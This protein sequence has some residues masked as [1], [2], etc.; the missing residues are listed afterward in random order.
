VQSSTLL[1]NGDLSNASQ[2]AVNGGTLGGTG[3]VGNT[4][5]NAGGTLAPGA[6]GS[7]SAGNSTL[8]ISGNLA[9]RSGA[10]YLVQVNPTLATNANVSGTATLTGGTVKTVFSPGTYV[11][12][13]YD[14]LHAAGGLGGTTFTGVADQTL[15][16]FT[17]SLSYTGDDVL[18]N[19][20]ASLGTTPSG[21]TP[22]PL[23]GNQQAVANGLNGYFNRGGALPPNFLPIFTS[24]GSNLAHALSQADGEDATGAEHGA[25]D[26]M[27]NF[28]GTL[29][30]PSV[31]GRGGDNDGS[32]SLT[33]DVMLA[34]AG[35]SDAPPK[36]PLARRWTAWATGFGGTATNDGD[37]AAGTTNLTTSTYGYAGGLDYHFSANTTFG[38][39]LGGGGTNWGLAQGMGTGSS[40]ALLAGVYG[41]THAGPAYVFGALGFAE[42]WFTTDRTSFAGDKLTASFSGQSYSAR[43]ETGY[44]FA[45][46][47]AIGVTP[48][49]AIQ[50]QDFY[51]PSYIETDVS[52][53]GFGLSY[54]AKSGVDTRSE[55]GAR[56]DDRTALGRLPL[57][58]RAKLAWAHDWVSNP[59]LDA[60]FTALPGSSFTVK[61][62]PI[63][64]NTALASVAAQ[65][66]FTPS[67]S[68]IAKFDSEFASGERLYAG[69]GTVRYTW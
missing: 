39:S 40:N 61:G 32:A 30:D 13:S 44:R 6:Q 1:V 57:I 24:T 41:V 26:L 49:A 48:Y 55:L 21:L 8:T 19:L 51:T 67:W 4:L 2:I 60:A 22:T 15:S 28:L 68:L 25:F 36:R 11:V 34:A 23:N 65:L 9:F 18:L 62:A 58:V 31:E 46:Q 17:Q 10:F 27:N 5:I 12:K 42:N 43:L 20:T 59:A 38:V 45:V 33:P 37:T 3:T 52:G 69:T 29:L 53:G 47:H 16:G 54:N 56:F 7:P 14:I 64:H 63:A 35:V 66:F 50:A